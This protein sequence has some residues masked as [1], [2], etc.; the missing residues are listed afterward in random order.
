VIVIYFFFLLLLL[1]FFIFFK[2]DEDGIIFM[3]KIKDI[4]QNGNKIDVK[5]L[6]CSSIKAEDKARI[7]QINNDLFLAKLSKINEKNEIKKKLTFEVIKLE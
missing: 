4:W 7:E 6:L 5:N 2:A 3:L 1:F